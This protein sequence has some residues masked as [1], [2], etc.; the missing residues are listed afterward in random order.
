MSGGEVEVIIEQ[1]IW[2]KE[3]V[4]AVLL[5]QPLQYEDEFRVL[6]T[7]EKDKRGRPRRHRSVA[8]DAVLEIPH[9]SFIVL[10]YVKGGVGSRI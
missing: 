10:L 3:P 9:A 7:E 5:I 8:D 4:A 6:A 2:Y 1:D